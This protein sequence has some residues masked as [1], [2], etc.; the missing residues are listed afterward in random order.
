MNHKLFNLGNQ[1][2]NLQ[3]EIM[4]LRARN[5]YRGNPILYLMES[6]TE[7]VNTIRME[8]C[9]QGSKEKKYVVRV[10]CIESNLARIVE[11]LGEINIGYH[12][13]DLD[14]ESEE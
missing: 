2:V 12:I 8:A 1:I 5:E 13:D 7:I 3:H 10:P 4:A 11:K 6:L 14:S 9:F